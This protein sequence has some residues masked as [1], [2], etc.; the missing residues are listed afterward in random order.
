MLNSY[1]H[2]K[3]RVG[4]GWD[5]SALVRL[6]ELIFVMDVNDFRQAGCSNCTDLEREPWKGVFGQRFPP[7][8]RKG[9]LRSWHGA[10]ASPYIQVDDRP[11]FW[12]RR[13]LHKG[14]IY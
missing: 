13:G 12:A 2:C 9:K 1:P 4:G 10:E 5:V 14:R 8:D 11:E 7:K 6:L 3:E